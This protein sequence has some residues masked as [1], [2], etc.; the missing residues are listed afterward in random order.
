MF[1][2]DPC[3]IDLFACGTEDK[4]WSFRNRECALISEPFGATQPNEDQ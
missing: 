3:H 4:V 1:L 2:T